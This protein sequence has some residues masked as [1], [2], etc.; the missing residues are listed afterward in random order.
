MKACMV[1]A[2]WGINVLNQNICYYTG[3]FKLYANV[4]VGVIWL[5][6]HRVDRTRDRTSTNKVHE[7]A[8]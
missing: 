2:V 4:M 8:C 1:P 3:C 7:I 5:R 6:T